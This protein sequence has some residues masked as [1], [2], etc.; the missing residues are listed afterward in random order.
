MARWGGGSICLAELWPVAN[1]I[2]LYLRVQETL[3]N[4]VHMQHLNRISPMCSE[5]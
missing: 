1:F 4:L 2:S 3:E 5:L